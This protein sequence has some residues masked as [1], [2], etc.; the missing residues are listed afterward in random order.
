[1]RPAA[2]GA[3][4]WRRKAGHSCIRGANSH[5]RELLF[6]PGW[7]KLP[8]NLAS[9]QGPSM[10]RFA[11][12]LAAALAL[13]GCSGSGTNPI[14]GS[15][16]D[17]T[18]EV[19]PTENTIPDDLAGNVVSLGFDAAGDK[20]TIEIKG[21]DA[22]P[23]VAN[24]DRQPGLDVIGNDGKVAYRAFTS[25]DDPL[26]RF[27]TALV[28]QSFDGSV[29]A[30]VEADGGQFTRYFPGGS[31]AQNGTY[32]PPTTTGLTSY[33]GTY[34]AVVNV[35]GDGTFNQPVP[36]GTDP[37]LIPG[38]AER[39]KGQIFLNVHF[40]E[41]QLNG[42]IYKRHY[43]DA[44]T[45]LDDV[46]LIPADI[47]TD[48]SFTGTVELPDQ[49]EIGSYGGVF[50]GNEATS[51]GGVVH[52]AGYDRNPKHEET[53][54]FVLTRCGLAGADTAGCSVAEDLGK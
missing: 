18:P 11:L 24:F 39:I 53:G 42:T 5:A 33:A 41:N 28:A 31:Y 27:Y 1:M 16:E 52:T 10:T 54:V 6:A 23:L 44:G 48:G 12:V 4:R 49:T 40:G 36:P 45:E 43:V 25:Q 17:D 34:A 2:R 35:D 38:N 30:G 14:T 46:F 32:S 22:D 7:R 15:D 19:P 50:G 8:Q 3:S 51:V 26:D 37:A 20:L 13:A 9:E 21:L 29:T 47:A